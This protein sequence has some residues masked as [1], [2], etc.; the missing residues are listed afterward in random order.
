MTRRAGWLVLLFASSLSAATCESEVKVIDPTGRL[1][2]NAQVIISSQHEQS[3]VM[4]SGKIDAQARFQTTLPEGHYRLE[5]AVAGFRRYETSFRCA[6][7]E[8]LY[9]PVRLE[10]GLRGGDY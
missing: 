8:R 4:S 1:T 2:E 5:V 6:K 10:L 3:R 9:F 7:S